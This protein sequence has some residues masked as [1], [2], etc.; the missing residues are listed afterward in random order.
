M[1][2]WPK[3][4]ESKS[5]TLILCQ[6]PLEETNGEP[7]QEGKQSSGALNVQ[8][9]GSLVLNCSYKGSAI[10]SLQWFGPWERTHI[11]VANS[12]KSKRTNKW[13][14][15]DSMDKLSRHVT[16]SVSPSLFW[17]VQ[18]AKQGLQLL[19]KYTSGNSLVS[20]I[21]GFE[22]EFKRN[23]TAFHLKK[24]SAHWRDSPSVSGVEVEQSPSAH[25]LQEG[26]TSMLQCNFS[27]SLN[28]VQW[29]RQNPGGHLVHLFY[30]PS[31]TKQNGRL[32]STTVSR[33]HRSSLYI[34]SSQTTD[35]A[36]Y[37]CAVGATVLPRH[38]QPVNK[39]SARLSISSSHS[40]IMRPLHIG[41]SGQQKEKS[42]QVKQSFS[43][44][45]VPEGR[46]SVLN[47]TYEDSTYD[48]FTWY[49][50]LPGEGPALLI[51]IRSVM[52]KKED[53]RFTVSFSKSAKS[54]SLHI[55]ASQLGDSATYFCA[56][57]AQCSP[58]TCSLCPNLCERHFSA[59]DAWMG[60]MEKSPSV[61]SLL[62]LW[63]HLGRVSSIPT[64]EQTPQSL[65]VQEGKSTNFTCNFPS[66]SFYALH[67]YRWEPAKSPQILFVITVNGVEKEDGR[68]RVT[69]NTKDGHS[70]LFI[71]G[72]QHEDSATYLCA[73]TQCSSGTCSSCPNVCEAEANGQQIKQIPQFL[74]LQEGEDFTTYCNSSTTVNSFQWYKQKPGGSPVLLIT[75]AKAGEVKKEKRLT[76]RFGETRKDS[77]LHITAAQIAD[78]GTYFCVEPQCSQSTCTL[79]PN[80]A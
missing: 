30:I 31:G 36:I 4:V 2:S 16:N 80:L 38:L 28:T 54:F 71:K 69:L 74:A 24:P 18:Y 19:L 17:Y 53:G 12:I 23:E 55:T 37:F 57:G 20:G 67:W 25:S 39:P 5:W 58:D 40:P 63:F 61:A 13:M 79:S 8:E 72:S 56:A 75:V 47:C 14:N 62:I 73:L 6:V 50:Q 78:V 41:V 60:Q 46:I 77:S 26:A 65:H 59:W 3:P 9:G 51:A 68:V 1:A 49:Q 70:C 48:Y 66:S 33:E 44:L 27:T 42:E 10:C 32:N 15:K 52:N 64:V 35:S 21:K 7:S 22:A 29:F 76:F 43:S 11:S 45:T 34:S